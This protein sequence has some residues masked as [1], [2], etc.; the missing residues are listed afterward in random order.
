MKFICN[1]NIVNIYD[2][3]GNV[4]IDVKNEK[5]LGGNEEAEYDVFC[6]VE[7]RKSKFCYFFI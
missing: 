6:G 4:E 1:V 7:A 5:R 3:N 2:L